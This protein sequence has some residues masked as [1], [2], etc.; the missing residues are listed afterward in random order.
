MKDVDLYNS[1]Y[2]NFAADV[3]AEIRR[4]T[5]GVDIGQNS[6]L[7]VEEY[8]QFCD[9]LKIGPDSS[10]LEVASGSGGPALY[11]AEKFGCRVT[12]VDVNEQG[13]KAARQAAALRGIN[14]SEFRTADVSEP[15]PFDDGVFDGVLCIDAANHF[16][17][18][19]GVLREWH[20]VLKPGG[21][22]VFTDPVVI[23]GPVSNE[24]I[25]ARS[26]IGF[27]IFM[28]ADT[29]EKFIRDA[30]FRLIDRID[31]TANIEL[32]SGRWYEARRR[33]ADAVKTI[34]DEERFEGLQL[35]LAAVHKLTKERRLSRIA[36][37]AEG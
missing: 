23:T 24:E 28:P 1:T 30:G 10:V 9:R 29:T 6:W 3:L 16:A 32:T 35:F 33:R 25:A 26:N 31:V 37:L 34:E 15:L 13:I 8:Q 12:G 18:R 19:L 21:R 20:R 5:Y 2:G 4:E 17:D 7:T 22:I 36:F 14:N 11:L 27:F